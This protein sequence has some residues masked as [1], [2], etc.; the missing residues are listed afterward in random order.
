MKIKVRISVTLNIV[1]VLKNNSVKGGSID[2]DFDIDSDVQDLEE[3][4][5]DP[6][7]EGF[8][9]QCYYKSDLHKKG[10]AILSL[11]INKVEKI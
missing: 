4:K 3:I 7:L 8:I 9:R 10:E 5:K 11:K 6:I 1:K 2:L